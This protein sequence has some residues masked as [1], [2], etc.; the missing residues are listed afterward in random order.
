MSLV[1]PMLPL[2]RQQ[3]VSKHLLIAQQRR[4]AG[5]PLKQGGAGRK[6]CGGRP[7]GRSLPR[8]PRA[9][10]LTRVSV[11]RQREGCSLKSQNGGAAQRAHCRGAPFNAITTTTRTTPRSQQRG[12]HERLRLHDAQVFNGFGCSGKNVSPTLAW[13]GAP[14][15]TK[16][17]ALTCMPNVAGGRLDAT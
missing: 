15:G 9:R 13:S 10:Q 7:A 12:R 6:R 3:R 11:G 16:S 5:R 2:Q 8:R 14:E 1:P 17:F 4:E